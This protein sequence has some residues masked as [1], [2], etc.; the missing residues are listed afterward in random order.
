M[1]GNKRTV[2]DFYKRSTCKSQS[3][4]ETAITDYDMCRDG[5][6]DR[7][8]EGELLCTLPQTSKSENKKDRQIFKY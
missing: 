6:A 4:S 2:F 8:A 3:D 1:A 5:D 7:D